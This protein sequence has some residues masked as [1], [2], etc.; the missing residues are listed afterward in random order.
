MPLTFNFDCILNRREKKLI[1]F[2]F[3][4]KYFFLVIRIK[5]IFL[6]KYMHRNSLMMKNNSITRQI[7][8]K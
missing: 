3:L 2:Y 1:T 5:R 7:K 8:E 6:M 4:K